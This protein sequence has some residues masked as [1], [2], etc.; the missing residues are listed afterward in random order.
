MINTKFF[1]SLGSQFPHLATQ[2][3]FHINKSL[4]CAIGITETMLLTEHISVSKQNGDDWYPLSRITLAEETGISH[5]TQ[6]R[7]E[8]V[9][10]KLGLMQRERR[11][12]TQNNWYKLNFERLLEL[13]KNPTT[14]MQQNMPLHVHFA[15]SSI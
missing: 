7:M 12:Q 13:I 15:N 1:R 5:S 9:F 14:F 8:R 4:A 6:L 3:Y 10:L 2:P 11:G